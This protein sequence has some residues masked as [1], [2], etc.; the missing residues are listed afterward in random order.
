MKKCL[1]CGLSLQNTNKDDLGYTPKLDNDLCMRCFKL[2]H[3]GN[4]VNLGKKQN[5]TKLLREIEKIN[6]HVLFLVDFLNIY[7]D[8]IDVYK[9]I[10]CSKSLVVTKSDLIPKNI[11]KDKLI[12][13]IK[14][15]Y[16][17]KED[18][19]L[20]SSKTKENLK[21]LEKICLANSTI[22][23]AGFTNAGKSSVINALVG[24]DITVSKRINTTQ[25]FIKLKVDGINIYDAPGFINSKS[26]DYVAKT[27]I[28]PKT[29]QLANKY[30]LNILDIV[31]ASNLDNNLTL[32]FD[33]SINVCKRKIKDNMEYN[34]KI[35]AGS[36]L[37]IKG[38]GFI[39]FGEEANI[40]INIAREYLDIRP[41]IIGGAHE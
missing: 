9:R 17:I 20:V 31:I 26:Y 18:I 14:D 41:T 2:K 39:K 8:V 10:K 36:D 13:N 22:V 12:K 24:S 33:N 3:Y 25:E 1:G 15:I 5:N 38:L 30:Y 37:V 34:L 21:I 6:G 35:P 16:E 11:K 23:F 27:M 32:Y 7:N 19:L 29:Y 4:L 40:C 28:K